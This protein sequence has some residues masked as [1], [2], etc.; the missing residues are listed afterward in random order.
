[1]E[2]MTFVYRVFKSSWGIVVSINAELAK[3]SQ[4]H[5]QTS[6]RKVDEGLWVQLSEKDDTDSDYVFN[7]EEN[8]LICSAIRMISFQIISKS[9]YKEDAIIVFHR[10]DFLFSDYQPESLVPAV[11]N[12]FANALDIEVPEIKAEYNKQINKYEFDY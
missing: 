2:P 3:M 5:K 9:P 4:Y 6:C 1:M 11:V 10:I 7:E 12:W 8:E